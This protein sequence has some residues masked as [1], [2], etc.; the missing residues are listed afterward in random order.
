MHRSDFKINYLFFVSALILYFFVVTKSYA[1]QDGILNLVN[2]FSVSL[3]Y[4]QVL[5]FGD[6]KITK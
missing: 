6:E 4:S 3:P 5:K 2:F 1:R